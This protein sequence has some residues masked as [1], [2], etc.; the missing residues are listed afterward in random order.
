[1]DR[2][3]APDETIAA[4]RHLF[5]CNHC[6]ER[7]RRLTSASNAYQDFQDQVLEP[8]LDVHAGNRHFPLPKNRSSKQSNRWM[9]L[10]IAASFC[11]LGVAVAYLLKYSESISQPITEPISQPSAQQVLTRAEAADYRTTGSIVF[12]TSRY[13]FTRPAIFRTRPTDA[14]LEHIQALFV[15]ARYSWDD[16][17]SARSFAAWRRTLHRREDEVTSVVE[18]GGGKLYQVKT[19]TPEGVLH[20][21]SLTLKADTYQATQADF[22]FQGEGSLQLTQQPEITGDNPNAKSN[23]AGKVEVTATPKEELRVFAALDAIGADAGDPIDIRLDPQRRSILVTGVGIS[24]VRRK[25]VENALLGIPAVSVEFSLNSSVSP[26][27]RRSVDQPDST[28]D[29]SNMLFRQK[30]AALF[31]GIQHLEAATDKALDS[32]NALFARAHSLR[33]LAR[34]FPPDVEARLDA[35]GEIELA[36][37]RRVE[38][39]SM[40]LALRNL[41]ERLTPLIAANSID[42]Q[43]AII[44]NAAWQT[45]ANTLF[46]DVRNL[47]AL[48]SRLLAGSYTEEMGNNLLK[49]LPASLSNVEILVR[50][51]S[52]GGR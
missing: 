26:E 50:L 14:R 41:K 42:N 8:L 27:D 13:R 49:Q 44:P 15:E 6:S 7:L 3:I 21:A 2:E 30:L 17:L 48:L 46:E 19:R 51:V 10:A 43:P 38:I 45:T 5:T 12:A 11:V 24:A 40:T 4:E 22:E 1:M 33:L 31:G 39:A 29:T 34:E 36:N 35:N 23:I 9:P 47:D 52:S 28:S 16:P 25:E 37:L 18:P 20:A 32:S